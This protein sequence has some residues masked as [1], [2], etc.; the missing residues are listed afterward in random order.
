MD[1]NKPARG[2]RKK[3]E[4]DPAPTNHYRRL[5]AAVITCVESRVMLAVDR[6]LKTDE[7]RRGCLHLLSQR[8]RIN[9]IRTRELFATNM[10]AEPVTLRA[11]AE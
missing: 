2:S 4:N 9:T 3:I 1:A 6:K 11:S 5:A 10:V 8:A 7:Y